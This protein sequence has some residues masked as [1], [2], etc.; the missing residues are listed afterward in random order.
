MTVD[1]FR[2]R[3]ESRQIC[4]VENTSELGNV[5]IC[6]DKD[7]LGQVF[8]NILENTCRYVQPP[9]TLS[10]R[11]ER[12]KK[13]SFF[14]SKIPVPAFLKNLC[15]GCSIDYTGWIPPGVG[16]VAEAGLVCP[17]ARISSTAMEDVSG[18][19]TMPREA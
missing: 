14:T 16:T 12:E 19:R 2:E 3:F 1:T 11:I 15:H 4:L 8:A 5:R 6:A 13:M 9:G 10:I 7:R 17:F 18:P